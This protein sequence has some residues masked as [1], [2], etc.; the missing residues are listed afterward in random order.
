MFLHLTKCF[1]NLS[2]TTEYFFLSSSDYLKDLK[3]SSASSP[4]V[5]IRVFT[6]T[7]FSFWSSPAALLNLSKRQIHLSH[8]WGRLKVKLSGDA[9]W[10]VAAMCSFYDCCICIIHSPFSQKRVAFASV[11]S[12]SRVWHHVVIYSSSHWPIGGDILGYAQTHEH[13]YMSRSHYTRACVVQKWI[14]RQ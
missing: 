4:I 10:Y 6:W 11:E 3:M 8:S 2:F 14:L 7:A 9:T 1:S 5:Y 12:I 13:T